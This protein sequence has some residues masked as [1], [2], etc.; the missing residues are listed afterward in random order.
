MKQLQYRFV[1]HH[2]REVQP[3]L[4]TVLLTYRGNSYEALVPTR[5]KVVKV[6]FQQQISDLAA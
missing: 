3:C 5:S 6:N 1:T 2:K 4:E